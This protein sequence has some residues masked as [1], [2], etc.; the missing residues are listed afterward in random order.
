MTRIA[1]VQINLGFLLFYFCFW[2]CFYLCVLERCLL[3]SMRLWGDDIETLRVASGT[4]FN[5]VPN[6]SLYWNSWMLLFK[7]FFM[8]IFN[9]I[10]FS[11]FI[12]L[13]GDFECWA[14]LTI[15]NLGGS[16]PKGTA[17]TDFPPICTPIKICWKGIRF[18]LCPYCWFHFKF[19]HLS[20]FY[21]FADNCLG[22][23]S[24]ES[25]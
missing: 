22:S 18:P 12:I 6:L 9:F 2:L 10:I 11:Y 4:I 19:Y 15:C 1:N 21:F 17:L 23:S 24:F 3:Y 7:F 13:N 14:P 16:K 25:Y 8:Y 20:I 5:E